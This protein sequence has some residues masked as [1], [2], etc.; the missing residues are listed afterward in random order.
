MFWVWMDDSKLP[1]SDKITRALAAYHGRFGTRP[2][3]VLTHPEQLIIRADVLV[4][5][6]SERGAIEIGRAHV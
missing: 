5:T 1:V 4:L 3:V 6:G 2:G